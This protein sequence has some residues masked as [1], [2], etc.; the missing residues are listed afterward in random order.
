MSLIVMFSTWCAAGVTFIRPFLP[1]LVAS[2]G[3]TIGTHV[4]AFGG[5]WFAARRYALSCIGSGFSGFTQ[6]YWT[7]GSATCTTLLFSH[8]A[9]IGVAAA[10]LITTLLLFAWLFYTNAKWLL[11]PTYRAVRQEFHPQQ[12]NISLNETPDC[13]TTTR[14]PSSPPPPERTVSPT[15]RRS[16]RNI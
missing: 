15:L 2:M 12:K 4:I 10:S 8:V 1:A 14:S 11:S 16:T 9:L 13:E 7:M 5:S 6:A 3:W